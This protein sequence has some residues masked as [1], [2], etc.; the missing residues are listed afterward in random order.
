MKSSG[1]YWIRNTLNNKKYIGSADDFH[2][3]KNHHFAALG[4]NNHHNL[5]LQNAYNKYGGNN[6]VF[7]IIEYTTDLT[8]R[9]N[10]WINN[11]Q[12]IYNIRLDANTNLGIKFT[13]EHK[14]NLSISKIG[15]KFS[16]KHKEKLSLAQQGKKRTKESIEKRNQQIR[17]PI[18]QLDKFTNEVIKFW[19]CAADVEK[20][21]KIDAASIA[22]VCKGK[23]KTSGG[24]RWQYYTQGEFN[25]V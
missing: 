9:E 12:N 4:R 11:T 24:F 16:E 25:N 18:L 14:R 1:I 7:E 22:A 23:L 15:V 5:H 10:W 2:I 20:E 8:N 21:I 3:R 17:K 19:P 6:F 13:D